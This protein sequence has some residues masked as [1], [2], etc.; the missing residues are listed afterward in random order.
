MWCKNHDDSTIS[1]QEPFI[2]PPISAKRRYLAPKFGAKMCLAPYFGGKLVLAPKNARGSSEMIRISIC[3]PVRTLNASR[4]PATRKNHTSV[5]ASFVRICVFGWGVS[6]QTG[7]QGSAMGLRL[8]INVGGPHCVRFLQASRE[9]GP[10][11]RL[12][13]EPNTYAHC[14]Q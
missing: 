9:R 6:D 4:A 1:R 11:G 5:A 7:V 8:L 10:V 13:S 14:V 3:R 2:F 12:W